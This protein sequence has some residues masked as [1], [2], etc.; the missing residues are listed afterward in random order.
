MSLYKTKSKAFE[1]NIGNKVS[2]TKQ[3]HKYTL[4]NIYICTYNSINEAAIANNIKYPSNI[5]ACCKGIS[6]NCK[7]FKWEYGNTIKYNKLREVLN[8]YNL[9]NNKHIP[10]SFIEETA[11]HKKYLLAGIIDSDGTLSN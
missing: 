1:V 9:L 7:G 8:F 3:V 5:V 10:Q 2:Y 11:T 6:S 4:D